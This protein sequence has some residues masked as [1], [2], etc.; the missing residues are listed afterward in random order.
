MRANVVKY[1]ALL[2]VTGLIAFMLAKRLGAFDS[3]TKEAES[4]ANAPRL[5]TV[6]AIRAEP[7]VL[8]DRLRSTGTLLAEESVDLTAEVSGRI[9]H[10]G[11][12]E[13]RP[14][15]K[16]TLLVKI[17]DDELQAQLRKT[18]HQLTLARTQERRMTEL[19]TIEAV[20]Q[21]ETDRAI[22]ER[23]SL[24]ADSALLRAQ[25][26]RTEIRAPF[27]GTAGLRQVSPG[28]FVTNGTPIATLVQ[29]SPLKLEFAVPEKMLHRLKVGQD[30]DF[31]TSDGKQRK[32]RVFA[33]QPGIDPATRSVNV[34]ARYTN[35]NADLVPGFFADV[36][37]IL[38]SRNDAL[39]VPTEA[40]IPELGKVKLLLYRGGGVS[41]VEV[42]TGIRTADEVEIA[43]GLQPGDTVITSG[44]LQLREGMPVKLTM[45]N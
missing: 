35:S 6:S 42:T 1:V 19:R 11:F 33:I 3:G 21:E 2:A 17:D 45:S 9:I 10:I 20:S 4:A 39:S 40:L 37:L 38:D 34:R 28:Q 13:G 15:Q 26:N 36:D 8:E 30:V 27:S 25:I 7:Q 24:E 22:T 29:T 23:M 14:V 5:M 16:G 18:V 12:E 41:Q 44:I 32:A 31:T 43:S